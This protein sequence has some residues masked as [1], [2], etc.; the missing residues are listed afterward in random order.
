[1]PLLGGAAKL[2]GQGIPSGNPQF[3]SDPYLVS[4]FKL[5]PGLACAKLELNS[6]GTI[7]GVRCGFSSFALGRWD[8][9]LGTLTIGDYDFRVDK[10]TG[11][12][13]NSDLAQDT[14]FAGRHLMKFGIDISGGTKNF[15]GTIR[16]RPTGGG[17]DFDT[18]SVN[19][20]AESTP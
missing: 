15:E 19:L 6:D 3:V 10:I 17:A 1:M 12:S 14:W 5:A 16:V 9:S 20:S 11:D 4:D 8:N 13:L 2:S 7:R 18:A